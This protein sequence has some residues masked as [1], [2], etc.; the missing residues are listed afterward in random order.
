MLEPPLKPPKAN[1]ELAKLRDPR[2]LLPAQEERITT[3]LKTFGGQKFTFSV[4][5]DS[6]SVEMLEVMDKLLKASGWI[7]TKPIGI[8]MLGDKADLVAATGI[9]VQISTKT[10][11]SVEAVALALASALVAE[12]IQAR[13][14]RSKDMDDHVDTLRVV[15]GRKP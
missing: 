4:S 9:A 15:I 2:K 7:W 3:R 13:A 12:G 10:E 1:L 11:P 8:I 5:S 6:E 14:E